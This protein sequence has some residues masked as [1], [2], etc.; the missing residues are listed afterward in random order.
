M[1]AP[2]PVSTVPGV[3]I[4]DLSKRKHEIS[5]QLM[6]AAEGVGFFYMTGVDCMPFLLSHDNPTDF[7]ETAWVNEV[8]S[9]PAC[10]AWAPPGGN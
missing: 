7:S 4:S 3:D 2:K 1:D 10:R 5:Q 6:K 8:Y 9:L